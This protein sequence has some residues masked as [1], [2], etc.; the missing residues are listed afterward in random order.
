MRVVSCEP[1]AIASA[2]VLLVEDDLATAEVLA[3]LLASEGYRVWHVA[4]AGGAEELMHSN[5]P[6][7]V[8][9][10]IMLPDMDGLALCSKL[11]AR[12]SV[13]IVLL[14]ASPRRSDPAV[15]L[16]LGAVDYIAKPYDSDDLLNRVASA[17]GLS[18]Q[19]R[20]EHVREG[21]NG[22]AIPSTM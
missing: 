2:D 19:T 7:L 22:A 14:S 11:R 13:P 21:L 8:I 5:P 1:T 4:E 6:D 12:W 20:L 15:G 16:R 10:D 9:L 17:L 18:A 3:E